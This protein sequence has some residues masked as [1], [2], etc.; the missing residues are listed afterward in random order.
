ME[1]KELIEY[2]KSQINNGVSKEEIT[3]ILQ[4]QGGWADKDINEA[5]SVIEKDKQIQNPEVEKVEEKIEQFETNQTEQS[6]QPEIS[7]KPK[8]KTVPSRLGLLIVL[9]IAIL[10]AVGAKWYMDYYTASE[11]ADVSEMLEQV[12]ENQEV[13]VEIVSS[14]EQEISSEELPSEYEVKADGVYYKGELIEEADPETFK[15]L[16]EFSFSKDKNHVWYLEFD[17]MGR[18]LLLTEL[19]DADPQT[20][21]VLTLWYAKDVQRVYSS[22][23]YHVSPI[24]GADS[25]TFITIDGYY[26]KDKNN[27]YFYGV[28]IKDS[29]SETFVGLG[30]DVQYAKD[31]K[32]VYHREKLIEDADPETFKIVNRQYT[33][34]KNNVYDWGKIVE[35]VDP[36]NCTAENL[37]GCEASIE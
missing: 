25:K 31:I 5:F 17:D 16:N 7:E 13:K 33:K 21:E 35:G 8:N 34:D 19:E 11:V 20:F 18:N 3:K 4:E 10:V 23:E 2:I 28:E 32:N 15:A 1:S 22:L 9:L 26:G 37:E 12:E 30:I 29:D 14:I 36:A 24:I 6:Q 27:V